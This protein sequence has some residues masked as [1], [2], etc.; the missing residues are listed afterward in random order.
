MKRIIDAVAPRRP[1]EDIFDD[2]PKHTDPRW[3]QFLSQ[4]IDQ[5]VM[6]PEG[7]AM[8]ECTLRRGCGPEG[9]LMQLEWD[10]GA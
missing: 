10:E 2:F 8:R 7:I 1:G 5:G 9:F 4:A 6:S 3:G